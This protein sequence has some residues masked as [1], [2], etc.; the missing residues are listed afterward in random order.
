MIK[1]IL[2]KS[3]YALTI[4]VVG[5]VL[6]YVFLV[7]ISNS[8]GEE[9]VGELSLLLAVQGVLVI[10]SVYGFDTSLVKVLSEDGKCAVEKKNLFLQAT[11]WTLLLSISLLIF[12]FISAEYLS[13][14]LSGSEGLAHQIKIISIAVV[15]FSFI[16]LNISVLR[17]E[18][19]I[20]EFSMIRHIPI[21]G[22]SVVGVFFV[23]NLFSVDERY[24]YYVYLVSIVITMF[25]SYLTVVG[26]TLYRYSDFHFMENVRGFYSNLEFK[27]LTTP[28]LLTSGTLFVASN[29][30]MVLISKFFDL[31]E[32]AYYSVSSKIA[33]VLILGMTAVSVVLAPKL[34]NLYSNNDYDGVSRLLKIATVISILFSVIVYAVLLLYI[35]SIFGLF[36]GGFIGNYSF[37]YIL[38]FANIVNASA[39]PIFVV[40]NMTGH[41]SSVFKIQAITSIVNIPVSIFLL[42]QF[43]S[44]GVAYGTLAVVIAQ[45]LLGLMF[46]YIYIRDS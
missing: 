11:S 33:S 13:V 40:L 2:S 30:D 5:I 20:F 27:R 16:L 7:L 1:E 6:S 34:S 26:K 23:Y 44:I 42:N 43:G 21:F 37:F 24:V 35:D 36:G 41:Q 9:F 14:F 45:Q 38:S 25:I 28:M 17:S 10:F 15:P 31:K 29:V 12:I 46:V 4:R 22:I 18:G 32:V 39:G 8:Y 19:M 3:S